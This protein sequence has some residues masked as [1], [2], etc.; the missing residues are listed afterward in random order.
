[1]LGRLIPVGSGKQNA[2]EIIKKGETTYK[3]EY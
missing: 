3:Q 2:D 1:M